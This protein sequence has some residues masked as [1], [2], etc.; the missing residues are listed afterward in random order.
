MFGLLPGKTEKK[1]NL[2]DEEIERQLE[3]MRK[4]DVESPE[5]KFAFSNYKELHAEKLSE[6]KLK[7]SKRSRWFEA[8]VT[9]V[10]AGVTLTSELWTPITSKWASSF[11]RPFKHRDTL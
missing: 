6:D 3:I 7:E 1:T 4:S 9:M 11:M 5:Y 8:G 10:L 2:L